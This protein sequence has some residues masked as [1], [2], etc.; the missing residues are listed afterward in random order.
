MAKTR[1]REITLIESEGAF[2]I[3]KK[4]KA[5]NKKYDFESISV[6][7]R[8][9]AKEKVKIL[10]VIKTQKPASI[11]DLAKKLSRN[12]KSVIEDLKLLERLGFIEFIDE[13]IKGRKRR[14]PIVLI[15]TMTIHLKI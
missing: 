6:L 15:D 1:V 8:L 12:F 4:S 9:L 3:F 14:R 2:S 11:Y 5:D 10:H 13:T 7:R